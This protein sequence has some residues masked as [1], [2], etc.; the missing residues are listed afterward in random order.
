MRL[1]SL[2]GA[3]V[4][5]FVYGLIVAIVLSFVYPYFGLA[6]GM[7]VSAIA[8]LGPIIY[9]IVYVWKWNKGEAKFP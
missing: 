1:F 8:S 2:I 6:I 9:F 3:I 5:Y 7:G 4:F